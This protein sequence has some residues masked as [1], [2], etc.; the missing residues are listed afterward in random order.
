M[1]STLISQ[2]NSNISECLHSCGPFLISGDGVVTKIIQGTIQIITKKH[3]CQQEED[4]E[5]YEDEENSEDAWYTIE[6]AFEVIT[7]LAAALGPQFAE[8]WKIFDKSVIA[9][10]SAT[11]STER[12]A[13]VGALAEVIR[14]MKGGCT[15]WT[16]NF[17]K[18]LLHR[19]SDEVSG[20]KSNA[21]YG[22]GLLVEHSED[23]TKIKK[24]LP[25]I[26]SK[27]EPILQNDDPQLLDNASGCVARLI[28]TYPDSVPIND[29]LPALVNLLPLKEDFE[30][31]AP[32]WSVIVKLYKSGN[33]TVQQLTSQIVRALET[34]LAEPDQMKE[35]TK[36]E[37]AELVKYLQGKQPALVQQHPGLAK[38]FEK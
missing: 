24:A 28:S 30:E 38:A 37:V 16:E 29:V 34:T 5:E 25:S 6:S 26:L 21:A 20:V 14:G 10:A 4:D 22:V 9:Y 15:P 27:L 1:Q 13:T 31:N 23:E 8:L 12:S 35:E 2:Y 33:S 17:L 19:L 36:A 3:P 7:G 32:V 18:I 11:S